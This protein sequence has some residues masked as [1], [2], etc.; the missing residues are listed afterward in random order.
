MMKTRE[1]D[2]KVKIAGILMPS[3]SGVLCMGVRNS[4][5]AR[6]RRRHGM[7]EVVS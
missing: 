7:W 4:S 6:A 3:R 1:Y 5:A 2:I